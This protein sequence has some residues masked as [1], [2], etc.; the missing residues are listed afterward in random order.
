MKSSQDAFDLIVTEEAGNQAYYTRHYQNWDW[1]GG[2]SGPTVGIGYDCGYVTPAEL[3]VDWGGI[4]DDQIPAL[5]EGCGI[6][7]E[8]AKEFV[9]ANRGSVT[10]TWDRAITEFRDREMPKWEGRVEQALPNTDQLSGDSFGALVSLAYNRGAAAFSA[11]G[12]R[13]TEMRAIKAYMGT[14]EFD[15]IPDEFLAMR[16]LWPVDGDLWKRREHEA[17]L[18]QWGLGGAVAGAI[19]GALTAQDMKWVQDSLNRLG[20]NPP[21]DVDG[22][23]GPATQ[24]AIISFQQ[25]AGVQPDGVAGPQTIAA[26]EQ[27][28]A[29]A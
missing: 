6:T 4:A 22:Q 7:G 23:S 26:I 9:N 13:Y 2:S 1:P 11:A 20:A 14:R 27:A 5:L 15:K 17:T 25:S 19:A 16:R 3:Q 21:L 18:F 12:D 29:N 28:L 8:T 24:A 10:I